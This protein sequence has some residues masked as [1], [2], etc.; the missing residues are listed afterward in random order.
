MNLRQILLQ[1]RGRPHR[2][3]IAQHARGLLD[4]GGKEGID[5]PV[6]RARPATTGAI[7][8]P[9]PQRHGGA[10]RKALRPA[11]EGPSAHVPPCGY[12]LHV[13]PAI[14]PPHGLSAAPFLRVSGVHHVLGQPGTFFLA[15][16]QQGHRF[17]A[18][19]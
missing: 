19:S 1:Q 5:A 17:F 2:R 11:L 18:F 6:G 13:L 10:D 14:Q 4:H 12:C 16:S 15:K 8:Q 9:F 3:S 7:R